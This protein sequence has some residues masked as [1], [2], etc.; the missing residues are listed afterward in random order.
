MPATPTPMLASLGPAGLSILGR[1]KQAS[2]GPTL[3]EPG[4]S[5]PLPGAATETR[6]APFLPQTPV[7]V[8]PQPSMVAP[9]GPILQ[10]EFGRG[11]VTAALSR[12]E[13][14]LPEDKIERA[15]DYDD[16][17]P[18]EASYQPFP[19]LPFLTDSPLAYADF[20]SEG[21][22]VV[23]KMQ[24]LLSE[25]NDGLSVDLQR[26]PQYE[27]MYWALRFTGK[28]VSGALTRFV[29]N[30]PAGGGAS[31]KTALGQGPAR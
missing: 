15:P 20:S 31:A 16:D 8:M 5:M 11:F 7:A 1:E 27:G 19:I 12:N 28:A 14:E 29:A 22:I 13:R 25:T 9:K 6:P 30:E 10:P 17:H 3:T 2:L 24:Y 18:D 21:R 26:G 23:R 4:E